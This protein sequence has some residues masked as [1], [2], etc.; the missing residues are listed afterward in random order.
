MDLMRQMS[1]KPKLLL[2]DA[3][4]VITAYQLKVWE[5]LIQ[6]VDIA[7]TATV[8][9]DEAVFYTKK[10]SACHEGIDLLGLIDGDMLTELSAT[11][12]EIARVRSVFDTSFNI[13]LHDGEVEALALL[14]TNSGEDRLFCT[15]DKAAI[16]ALAMLGLSDKGISF[17]TVLTS[18]GLQKTLP[19]QFTEQYFEKYIKIGQGKRIQGQGV[20]YS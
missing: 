4:V 12:D 11:L 9:H 3:D 20:P 14:Y 17:E 7:V 13:S 16:Q 15:G 1:T 18:F 6:C 5:R 2:I 10:E 8:A 19:H